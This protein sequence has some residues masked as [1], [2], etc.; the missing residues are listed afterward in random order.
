MVSAT[1]AAAAVI[2][3]SS[4]MPAN[5]DLNKFEAETRGEFGIGSAAQFGSADLKYSFYCLL[6][7]LCCELWL[8][9]EWFSYSCFAFF[10]RKAVHVN[11]NF[12]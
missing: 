6:R 1:L 5:A 4:G 8:L 3:F 11:E 7:S 10:G 12:R 9:N 2:S